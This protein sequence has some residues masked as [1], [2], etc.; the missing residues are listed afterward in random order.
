MIAGGL[1]CISIG[2]ILVA[3]VIEVNVSYIIQ[4]TYR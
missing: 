1:V 3:A 2:L 4:Q